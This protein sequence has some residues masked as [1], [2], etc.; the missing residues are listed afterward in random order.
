MLDLGGAPKNKAAAA[1]E[2][3][4]PMT[5]EASSPDVASAAPASGQ[6]EG[7]EPTFE[8]ETVEDEEYHGRHA[9]A[10]DHCETGEEITPR[11]LLS[12]VRVV[13]T[14]FCEIFRTL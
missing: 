1:K 4:V 6:Q 11:D 10:R 3:E 5:I 12:G 8:V 7:N 14:L 13:R 9:D 2:G